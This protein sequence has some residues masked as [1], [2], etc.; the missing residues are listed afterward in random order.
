MNH[1][2]HQ[3]QALPAGN[4]VD[5][6]TY[7]VTKACVHLN[8]FVAAA[9]GSIIA[10]T[11]TS[12]AASGLIYVNRC[13]AGCTVTPGFD[14]AITGTSSIPSNVSNLS[15][16]AHGD[17]VFSD[18]VSCLRSLFARYDVDVILSNPGAV[19]RREIMIAGN[20]TQLSASLAGAPGVAPHYGMITDNA[21]AFAFANDIGADPD[22][23]CW[24][25]AA[26]LGFLYGLEYDVYCPD[27]VTYGTGCGLKT[28][29]DFDAPCGTNAE[30]ATCP[31]SGQPTQNSA[32]LLALRAGLS[33]RLFL[34]EFEQPRP[35]P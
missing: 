28:F 19:A 30:L 35:A 8:N 16:F 12:V 18:T 1:V 3:V 31:I 17:A 13:A 32:A 23:L 20:A 25:A 7:M 9:I 22:K 24:V 27:I 4:R 21:I 6:G 5:Y 15:A 11:A 34:N 26:Q 14:N 33:D 2:G 29:A 10:L